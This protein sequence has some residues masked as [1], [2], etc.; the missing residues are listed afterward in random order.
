[1]AAHESRSSC[2]PNTLGGSFDERAN[3]ALTNLMAY[4]LT[5]DVEYHRLDD[6]LLELARSDS[7]AEELRAVVRERD[8]VGAQREA[9][10][11]SV[12]ALRDQAGQRSPAGSP[13]QG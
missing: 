10:R 1:M 9:F 6:R 11:R 4:A 3:R 12:T 13:D 8:E 5:L 2:R 7:E